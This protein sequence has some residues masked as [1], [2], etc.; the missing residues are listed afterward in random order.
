VVLPSDNS[1]HYFPR[2][3]LANYTTKLS[4]PIELEP[5][6]WEVGLVEISYP[7][8]YKK[9]PLHNILKVH[10]M[11]IEFPIRHYTSLRVFFLS[12][13]RHFK[14]PEEKQDFV[15]TFHTYLNKHVPLDG[16]ATELLGVSYG[17]N[18]L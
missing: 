15:S 7:K 5:N 1:G 4:T 6:I 16:Y 11:E 17:Q 8:G 14:T 10:S 13:K 18:S 2:N 9:Q 3:T 12:L